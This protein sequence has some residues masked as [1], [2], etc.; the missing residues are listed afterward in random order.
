MKET[1]LE[2][3]RNNPR[4]AHQK[5]LWLLGLAAVI[6]HARVLKNAPDVRAIRLWTTGASSQSLTMIVLW[7][8]SKSALV[9]P[10]G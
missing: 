6:A 7:F 10:V 1:P 2:K 8:K 3:D 5:R 4:Q 9:Q